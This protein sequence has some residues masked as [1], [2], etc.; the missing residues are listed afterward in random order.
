MF[1]KKYITILL[2]LFCTS[3]SL[4]AQTRRSTR[5]QRALANKQAL[6]DQKL[7]Q[8]QQKIPWISKA[9]L[10]YGPDK[11]YGSRVNHILHHTK[12][13]PHKPKHSIFLAK[14]RKDIFDLIDEAW[15]TIKNPWCNLKGE[16]NIRMNRAIGT[17]GEKILR[18]IVIPGTAQIITA[19]P[20]LKWK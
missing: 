19:Y 13:A 7:E 3:I 10:I 1:Y 20:I 11:L 8:A 18:I 6:E 4:D 15:L 2:L 17:L 16:F 9:G 14:R 5:N 12:P